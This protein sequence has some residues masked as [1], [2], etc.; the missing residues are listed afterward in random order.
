MNK[1][2]HFFLKWLKYSVRILAQENLT[3]LVDGKD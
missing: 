1:K 3:V 2:N